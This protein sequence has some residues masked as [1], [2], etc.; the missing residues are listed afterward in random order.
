[1]RMHRMEY[2]KSNEYYSVVL[3][4]LQAVK[5][6]RYGKANRCIYVF[7]TNTPKTS[8][9]VFYQS[10]TVTEACPMKTC[11]KVQVSCRYS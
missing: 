5:R 7:A 11:G 9:A 3:E 6:H 1:M 4:L 8:Q 2:F 10:T